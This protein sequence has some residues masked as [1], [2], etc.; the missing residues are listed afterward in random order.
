MQLEQMN[1]E[2][3]QTEEKKLL[4][5][6]QQF[7]TSALKL[8]LTRGKPSAE[9]LT[10]SEG[11]E[12]LLAGKMIHEDG[13][14]LRNYGGADG[15]KEARQLGGDML[16]LPAEEVMVGDHTSLTIMYLYLLHAFY[17]GVQGP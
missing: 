13:T 8:D 11:M 5:T 14:D 1:L 17:H 2:Q 15:I 9:Q 6:H 4:S 10:L 7:Q 3:L 12:G 16:G